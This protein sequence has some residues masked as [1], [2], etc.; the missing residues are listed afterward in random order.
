MKSLALA[1]LA[2]LALALSLK[3]QTPPAPAVIPLYPQKAP[4]SEAWTYSEQEAPGG[5]VYNVSRPTLTVYRADPAR[6]SGTAV[7]VCP[8]GAFHILSMASEGAEIARWLNARGITAFVLKYRLA[9]SKTANPLGEV[10]AKLGDMQ[11]LDEENDPVVRLAKDDGLNAVKHVRTQAA[12]YGVRTDRIGI[13]GFSA[14]GTVTAS[15]A[16]NYAADSRP[17]F[18]APIYLYLKA[19]PN[20]DAVPKDAPPAFIAAASDDNLGFAPESV[21]LYNAWLAAGR[22]AELHMY[23]TG[24]HGFG[25]GRRGSASEFW[26]NDFEVWLRFNQFLPPAAR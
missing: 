2:L 24:G 20:Q 12:E 16:Y 10:M 26:L 14:G 6:A 23:A 22:P 7:V 3:A 11:K 1:P 19:V 15:V 18:I 9:E 8:G 4:G 17:D 25:P 21:R 13:M 5:M